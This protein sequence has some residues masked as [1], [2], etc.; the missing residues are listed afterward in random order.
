MKKNVD[1]LIL[2][3]GILGYALIPIPLFIDLSTFHLV[4][5]DEYFPKVNIPMPLSV[6]LLVSSV[7]LFHFLSFFYREEFCFL[8]SRKLRYIFLCFFVIVFSWIYFISKVDILKIIQVL[9]PIIGGIFFI[10]PK[11]ILILRKIVLTSFFFGFVFYNLHFFYILTNNHNLR[12][13]DS[14]DF[15][16]F[17]DFGIYQ[18]LVSY[19]GVVFLHFVVFFYLLLKNS[20]KFNSILFFYGGIIL[21]TLLGLAARRAS[22]I[23]LLI[24]LVFSCIVCLLYA[25]KFNKI[26][27]NILVFIIVFV[28]CILIYFMFFL[29]LPIFLRTQQSYE[30]GSFGTSRI[31]IYKAAIETFSNNIYQFLIGSPGKSGFHNYFLD[32]LFNLGLLP[33]IILMLM[34]FV[35]FLS[36]FKRVYANIK[37]FD[38]YKLE[39]IIILGLTSGLVVQS[40]VN[41]SITQPFYLLNVLLVIMLYVSLNSRSRNNGVK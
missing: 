31:E 37:S 20:T 18:A 40:M 24:F 32:V 19:P 9:M 36:N 14:Y 28:P 23:E 41:A 33:I 13:V 10:Y 11:N 29:H 7:F 35:Y 15:V 8:L 25:F 4:I 6:F 39:V 30:S 2:I 1:Y 5:S 17:F 34:L 27:L 3:L 38:F 21:L 22:L 26:K 12:S 16:K